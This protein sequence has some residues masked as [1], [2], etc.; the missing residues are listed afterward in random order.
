MTTGRTTNRYTRVYCDGYD[1]S[2]YARTIGPLDCTYDEH[3]DVVMNSD[4]KAA[5]IGQATISPGTLSGLFDN[6]ATTGIHALMSA[7]PVSRN[8]MVA[9]GIAAAPAI[10]DPVF[11]GQFRQDSYITTPGDNPV[12]VN[13]AFSPYAVLANATPMSY[14]NPWG[15]LLHANGAETAA[16]PLPTTNS[17]VDL[18]E[19]TTDGGYMFYQVLDAAGAG[20][21]TATIIVQDS[22][23][24]NDG[25][26]GNLLTSGVINCGAAGV[27]VPTKGWV[28][29]AIG[30]TVKRYV[31]WQVTLGTATSVTFV[32][33][34]AKM[35][36]PTT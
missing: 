7:P 3:E 6:T 17:G 1:L 12:G 22:T 5:M 14:S 20:D 31:R 32:L 28:A 26:F 34:F 10:G 35:K 18:L 29:L 19:E 33:G 4:Y 21:C 23:S 27:A 9:M 16:S 11:M 2:G 30:S 15:V 36:Y 13:I 8:V 24:A 25:D